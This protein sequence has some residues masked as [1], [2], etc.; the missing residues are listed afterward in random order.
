MRSIQM[1][2]YNY[3]E[4]LRSVKI[5]TEYRLDAAFLPWSAKFR[6][7]LLDTFPL[8]RQIYPIP[9]DVLLEPKWSLALTNL[10]DT[11]DP[12]PLVNGDRPQISPN[13]ILSLDTSNC[14]GTTI[15]TSLDNMIGPP[16][17]FL[18]VTLDENRRITAEDHWQDV[19]H[20]VLT[21][22]CLASYSPGDTM[23]IYPKN[24][25]DD[26]N[27]FLNLMKW[28]GIA[29]EPIK[30]TR[31]GLTDMISVP[32]IMSLLNGSPLT[33]RKLLYSHLDI[34]AI[35][36]RSFFVFIAHFARNPM[37]RGRIL[38]FTSPEYVDELYDYTTRPRRSILEVLQEF[39]S[40][41]IPWQWA[42]TVLPE[43]RGRQF[44]IASGGQLK[45]SDQG[46]TRFELCIAIVT[47]KTVI[48]KI[49]KGVCTRYLVGLPIGSSMRVSVQRGG[50]AI[51][52][53]DATRPVVMIGPGTGV[54]PMRSLIWERLQWSEDLESQERDES[55]EVI[56][57]TR[58]VAESI[59]FFGCRNQDKDFFYEEEWKEL[60]TRMDLKVFKAFSR[61]QKKKV[62]VQDLVR[63]QSNL[64][65]R[66]LYQFDGVVYICG[67]SGK[68][69]QAVREAL[70]EV[71]QNSNSM[72]REDAEAY[73]LR[74][75]KDGRYKQETW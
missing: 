41:E 36:R 9:E 51:R 69:P 60:E 13:A 72:K 2:L 44:S 15:K 3:Y 31:T 20:L 65:F 64:V 50:L 19:R 26:V 55:L 68:M 24:A 66:L 48:K 34:T 75:E 16:D 52:K 35:P 70:I 21:A 30:L 28:T 42:A 14:R 33:L 74:M 17:E 10:V 57:T 6:E 25:E 38:E 11:P 32:P 40:V 12:V 23:T 29:D 4:D 27:C 5:D 58:H 54:A 56:N 43:L 62:Y 53:A 18:E 59:L 1:G 22:K 61:D 45:K 46:I 7:H 67:S 8:D 71:F 37:Q 47:Y 39:D 73:L 63:E 49:R